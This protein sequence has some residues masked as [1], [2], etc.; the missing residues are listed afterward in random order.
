MQLHEVNHQGKT[1]T[2]HVLKNTTEPCP[3]CGIP[4]CGKE[5]I[6]WYESEGKRMAIISDGENMD[7]AIGEFLKRYL[8]NNEY[9]SL[10]KF[11]KEQNESKG[12]YEAWNYDG[13]ELDIDDFLAS[14]KL[15]RNEGSEKWISAE[16]IDDFQNL[17]DQARELGV[18]LKIVRG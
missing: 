9:A 4:A 6:L 14:L 3:Q 16:E 11:V 15:L 13:F 5:N 8:P 17:A 1:Y 10:P 2:F 12:W 7:L 18:K